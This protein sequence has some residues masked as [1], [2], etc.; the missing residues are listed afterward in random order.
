[1]RLPAPWRIPDLIEE[2][3]AARAAAGGGS[4][5]SADAA[6]RTGYAPGVSP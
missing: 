2:I 3:A 1:V 6:G 4:A 5:R